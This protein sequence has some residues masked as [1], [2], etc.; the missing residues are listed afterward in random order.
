M[1][2]GMVE[3]EV[4]LYVV[5]LLGKNF[6]VQVFTVYH[7]GSRMFSLKNKNVFLK[8]FSYG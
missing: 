2:Y 5:D 3:G 8:R 1:G 6:S 4:N 7:L